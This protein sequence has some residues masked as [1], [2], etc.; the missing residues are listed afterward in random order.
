[1]SHKQGSYLG[2][3]AAQRGAAAPVTELRESVERVWRHP[4]G[5]TRR[6]SFPGKPWT[7][8][9]TLQDIQ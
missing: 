1:M 2:P 8:H 6:G 4:D 7:L 9:L 3:Q 5:R